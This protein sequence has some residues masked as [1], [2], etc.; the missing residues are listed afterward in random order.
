MANNGTYAT[1]K[2]F[3]LDLSA[4]IN[5]LREHEESVQYYHAEQLP[6]DVKAVIEARGGVKIVEN[7]Y[8]MLVNKILGYKIASI[9]EVKVSGRQ[10]QDKALADLL[11]DLTKVFSQSPQYDKSII[12]KDFELIN[13]MAVLELG[14]KSDTQN[15][16]EITLKS[17]PV[18]CF[19][20][21]KYSTDASANDSRR[22]HKCLN[23]PLNQARRFF[24]EQD[25]E[26]VDNEEYDE[27]VNLKESWIKEDTPQGAVWN[28]YFWDNFKILKR[29]IKPFKNNIHPFVIGKFKIDHNNQWYGL[30]REIKSLQDYINFAENRMA[31]M[32]GSIKGFYEQDA[33]KDGDE[34]AQNASI[35]NAIV[36]VNP[37][38]ISGNKI[39]FV[40]QN[41]NVVAISQKVNEKRQIAKIL[42]GLNDEA[43]GVA[44]NRQS[45]VAIAQRRD[46]GLMGL[47]DYIKASDEMEKELFMK[48]LDLMQHYFTKKQTFKIVDK[49]VG[50]R[51]FEI[52]SNAE[53]RIKIGKFDLVYQSSLKMQGREERFAHWSEMLK[54]ISSI[55]PELVG[56]LLP[57][58][59]KDTDSPIVAEVEELIANHKALAE[60]SAQQT[61]PLQ[62]AQFELELQTLQAKVAQ[63]M[64]Q[65]RKYEAQGALAEQ[66][67]QKQAQENAQPQQPQSHEGENPTANKV[68]Q[69]NKGLDLR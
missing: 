50:E 19:L 15:D 65:A 66:V 37:G 61:Q 29:E 27:R 58:M 63:M 39:Q 12:K 53:N 44:Q 43:L 34:F 51:Y 55:K 7:I 32:L 14:L 48:V 18:K 13:G 17:V 1:K 62:Q 49:K 46:A 54:T 2:L 38:A 33:V 60:Q 26:I 28:R 56:D 42:S 45:G 47:Q 36:A 35:D 25:F 23:I 20:I 9:Q 24:G 11:N 59:L 16:I 41:S 8:K 40:N 4:N 57:L 31:N 10:E 67:A 52:N 3:E 69:T 6:P 22:F 64:A 21:D 30:F 5:S 68:L